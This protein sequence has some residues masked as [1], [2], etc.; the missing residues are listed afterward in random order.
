V[1]AREVAERLR[2]ALPLWTLG[3]R[4]GAF[5]GEEATWTGWYVRAFARVQG[6][7]SGD[8]SAPQ[9]EAA[10]AVLL[11][12]L[13]DQC[14][15]NANNAQRM[16]KLE[17]HLEWTGLALFLFTLLVAADHFLTPILFH[18]SSY[19]V[20]GLLGLIGKQGLA[21]TVVVGLGAALPALATATYG[22]RVIGDFEGIHR[23][24]ERTHLALQEL[25]KAVEEDP[26]DLALLRARAR[27]A[28]DIM[29]GDVSSWRL[30]AESR[31]LAIPG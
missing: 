19:V 5:P 12:V 28:A 31:G 6:L 3:L 4:P 9:F 8:F 7:R 25:I 23:R 15:Y 22:I 27:S 21:H 14:K 24:S 1:E 26:T 11:S 17:S 2:I 29:L 16:G 10:R 30:S 18:A 20:A 13:N